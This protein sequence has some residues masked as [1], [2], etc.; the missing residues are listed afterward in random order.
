[1]DHELKG[2][3]YL[4]EKP[5]VKEALETLKELLEDDKEARKHD[6]AFEIHV[7]KDPM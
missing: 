7:N 1:M 5:S 4:V 3:Q 6:F 2:P